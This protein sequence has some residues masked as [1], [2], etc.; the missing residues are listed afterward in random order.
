MFN[1]FLMHILPVTNN[2]NHHLMHLVHQPTCLHAAD[3]NSCTIQF[4]TFHSSQYDYTQHNYT[5]GRIYVSDSVIGKRAAAEI[6]FIIKIL[7][8]NPKLVS[9]VKY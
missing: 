6:M 2:N 9:I 4:E 3:C 1:T 5:T 7:K 8:L